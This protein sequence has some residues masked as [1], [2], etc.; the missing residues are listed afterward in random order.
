MCAHGGVHA[1][2]DVAGCEVDVHAA[3]LERGKRAGELRHGFHE[4]SCRA[5]AELPSGQQANREHTRDSVSR[6]PRRRLSS[7][8]FIQNVPLT[9][10]D[11]SLFVF[12]FSPANRSKSGNSQTNPSPLSAPG[13]PTA[14]L[15]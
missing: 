5:G 12:G 7:G 14:W 6:A 4:I 13:D 1:S 11:S 3:D 10:N 15:I 8:S 9:Q 2:C